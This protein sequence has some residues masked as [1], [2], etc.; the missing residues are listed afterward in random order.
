MEKRIF[1]AAFFFVSAIF[2]LLL[3]LP[4]IAIWVATGRS[5]HEK[6]MEWVIK[7]SDN[8]LK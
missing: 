1:Y 8:I 7:I 6:Y 3:T 2:L 4:S 5:F